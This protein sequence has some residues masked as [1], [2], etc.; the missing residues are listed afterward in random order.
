MHEEFGCVGLEMLMYRIPV[1]FTDT[2]GLKGMIEDGVSGLKVT[3]YSKKG[4]RFINQKQLVSKMKILLDNP[5]YA[6]LLGN[7]GRNRFLEKYEINTFSQNLLKIYP[8]I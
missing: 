4:K 5:E 7:N 3:V 6:N 2:G 8:S 1:V